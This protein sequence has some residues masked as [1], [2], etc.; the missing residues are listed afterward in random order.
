MLILFGLRTRDRSVNVDSRVADELAKIYKIMGGD[1]KLREINKKEM[2][3]LKERLILQYIATNPTKSRREAEK[4]LAGTLAKFDDPDNFDMYRIGIEKWIE[5]SREHV[6]NKNE[7]GRLL[8]KT[9]TF[10]K[11]KKE[12]KEKDIEKALGIGYAG[13][14]WLLEMLESEKK[15]ERVLDYKGDSSS[16]IKHWKVT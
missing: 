16:T 10:I 5:S 15:V 12:V 13:A 14:S 3:D 7:Y 4:G 6:R 8:N 1:L 2:A 11:D 9:K